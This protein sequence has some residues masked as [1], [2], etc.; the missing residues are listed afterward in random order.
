M[1]KIIA[2]VGL[3]A[4][5]ASGVQAALD[6]GTTTD[7]AKPWNVSATLRGFYDD[8]VSGL[9]NNAALP[10]GTQRGSAGFEVS[11]SILVSWPLEQTTITLGYVYSLKYYDV[12]P[13]GNADNL[14]QSHDFNASVSHYFSER[15]QINVRD[16]FVIGQEPDLLRAGNTYTT[17][18][19][20]PGNNLRN[21]GA[22]NFEAQITP[23]LGVEAGY[24]NTFYSYADDQ[25]AVSS[26]GNV[27]ASLSGLLDDID[28]AMHLDGRW[29]LQPQTI[30]VLGYQFRA[31]NYTAGQPIG[32]NLYFPNL[33]P[34][35]WSDIRDSTM[36]Y[37]YVGLDHNF[38]PDLTGSI[39]AGGRYN[40]YP[41]ESGQDDLSPYGLASLRYTY[42]PE[43][44]LEAGFSYDYSST[45][46]SFSTANGANS[47]TLN[48]QSASLFA[49]LR[50]RITPKLYGSIIGNFQDTTYYGGSGSY[51]GQSTLYYLLGLNLEY[52]FTHNFSAQAGYNYDN[53]Y[54]DVPGRTYDRNRVYIGVTAN[55]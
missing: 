3:V 50:H 52:R 54:S 16:S 35:L 9:G 24:A 11:P 53:V 27:T 25:V 1:K 22:I 45:D 20:I 4:L 41:N 38:Q 21:Y 40:I 31:V 32:G 30:G 42:R 17:F 43:S 39:R 47:V 51:N 26:G 49:T 10:P 7:T 28:Q 37:G 46:T 19:R 44:Y 14:D 34:I 29:Q 6:P 2:S 33:S 5:G 15:Y 23:K 18:Q 36:H 48:G 12:K 13:P 8:N 55:Y